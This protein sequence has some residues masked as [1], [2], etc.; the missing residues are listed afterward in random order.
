MG[1][2]EEGAL[3]SKIFIKL[4]LIVRLERRAVLEAKEKVARPS[5]VF[6]ERRGDEVYLPDIFLHGFRDFGQCFLFPWIW[7]NQ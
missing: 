3:G 1:F 4:R 5:L 6:N 7:R 2:E